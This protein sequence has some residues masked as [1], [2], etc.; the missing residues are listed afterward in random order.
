METKGIVFIDKDVNPH[1][2][3]AKL[4]RES[5]QKQENE[6]F[7][8]RVYNGSASDLITAFIK[9]DM[10]SQEEKEKLKQLLDQMD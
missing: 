9:K 1:L 6:S 2:Y 5:Y 10:I 4:D 8:K 7:L 3:L